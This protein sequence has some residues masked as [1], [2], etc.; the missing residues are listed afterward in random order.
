MAQPRHPRDSCLRQSQPM[1]DHHVQA[2][3]KL[4]QTLPLSIL[5]AL[6]PLSF[7]IDPQ[8]KTMPPALL[9]LAG[10]ALL[11]GS[12]ACRACFRAAWRP[13]AAALLMIGFVII[14]VLIH[15]LGWRPLDHPAH[16]L[17]LLVV[18]ACFSLPLQ[19]RLIWAGF[20]LTAMV[21]GAIGVL[22]THLFGIER[23]YGLNG[24]ASAAI[25]L[26]TILLGLSAMA[27]VQFLAPAKRRW[28]RVLH[29]TGMAFGMY[30]AL[31]TQSR[32]PLLAFAPIF[33]MLV[34]LHARRTGHWRSSL[35][36]IGAAC[37]IAAAATFSMRGE[38]KARF[39]AIAPEVT[40]FNHRND[41][42]GAVRERLEMWRTAARAFA[43]HPVLGIGKGEFAE[44]THQE[45]AAG[46]SNP[47]IGRYNQPHNEYLEAAA[48]GGLPGLLVLLAVFLVPLRYFSRYVLA[49]DDDI[50]LPASIGVA[51]IGLYMLCALTDAVFYRVMTQSFYFFLVLGL[52]VRIGR[53]RRLKLASASYGPHADFTPCA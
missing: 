52:A 37:A 53:L 38:M 27:L 43:A 29:L 4:W 1:E 20:S 31:L 26:A 14:N 12:A 16:I 33:V 50:A 40:S 10:L 23:A 19:M 18:A 13:I 48:T 39:E 45:I 25:E 34:L 6:M 15:Q 30:G 47:V 17:L 7:S 9:F 46:R 49:A 24:G 35:L 3:L 22:Q 21:L 42:R 51:L 41:A 5:V 44:Y 32:G 8:I 2:T 28:E 36:L 11:I